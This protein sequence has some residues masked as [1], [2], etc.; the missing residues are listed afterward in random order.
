[1]LKGS[2]VKP[3]VFS[4]FDGYSEPFHWK[5]KPKPDPKLPASLR[6]LYSPGNC[7]L[8]VVQLI[9]KC[10]GILHS[11]KLS[12]DQ[13]VYLFEITKGQSDC[14]EWY[15]QRE[16]RITSSIAHGVLNTD[17]LNPSRTVLKMV[18]FPDTKELRINWSRQK[19]GLIVDTDLP[20]IGASADAITHCDCH[21]KRVV[22]VKCPYS[23]RDKTLK[24]F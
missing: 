22:E 18:C 2:G 24:D 1:M 7:E 10:E 15:S 8:T 4:C 17:L 13:Q 19:A 5:R 16:G 23:F 3:V 11:V 20:F 6:S 21:G 14:H 9:F 12:A